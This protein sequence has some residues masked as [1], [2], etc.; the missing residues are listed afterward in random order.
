MGFPDIPVGQESTCNAGDPPWF[1]SWVGKILWKGE[2]LPTPVFLGF[3]CGSAGKESACSVGDLGLISGLGGSPGEGKG[4][5]LQYSGLEKSTDCIVPWGRKESDT[6]GR[7][8]LSHCLLHSSF[9]YNRS[10]ALQQ[11]RK[12]W[13]LFYVHSRG[14]KCSLNK[15]L[16]VSSEHDCL[17]QVISA[18]VGKMGVYESYDIDILMLMEHDSLI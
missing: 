12:T 1:N 15:G 8:S 2:W 9:W 6:T 4:Y 11:T 14:M 16:T 5:P 10:K 3:P 7:L 18:L 13:K 17:H